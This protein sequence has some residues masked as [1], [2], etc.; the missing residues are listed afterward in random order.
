[1]A[2]KPAGK[3]CK[4]NGSV[5]ITL[6]TLIDMFYVSRFNRDPMHDP[7]EGEDI[8]NSYKHRIYNKGDLKELMV[9]FMSFFE[10]AINDRNIGKIYLTKDI[11]LIRESSLPRIKYANTMDEMYQPNCKAG[12][13]YI[14]QGRYVWHMWLE[15]ETFEKMREISSNDPEFVKK[16]QELIPV[17]EEKNKNAKSKNRN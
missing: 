14:T 4:K 9:L 5:Y 1:M 12:E 3:V 7:G 10:K 17:L 13:Y 6:N 2:N 16:R 8:D 15:G 11:T